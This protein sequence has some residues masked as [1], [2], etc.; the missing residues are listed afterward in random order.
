MTDDAAL[1]YLYINIYIYTVLGKEKLS[2]VTYLGYTCAY[3]W[4]GQKA[5]MSV[6]RVRMSGRNL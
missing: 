1:H 3:E 2:S 5:C 4:E 6:F